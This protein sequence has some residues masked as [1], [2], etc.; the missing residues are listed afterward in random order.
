MNEGILYEYLSLLSIVDKAC[1]DSLQFPA[2]LYICISTF[3]VSG[4]RSEMNQAM[5]EPASM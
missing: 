4:R 1:L 2:T 5:Q 3:F